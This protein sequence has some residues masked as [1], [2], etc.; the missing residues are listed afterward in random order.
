MLYQV[1]LTD[2]EIARLRDGPVS[3]KPTADALV[4]AYHE[5]GTW[6]AGMSEPVAWAGIFYG[7]HARL[8]RSLEEWEAWRSKHW[9]V[10]DSISKRQ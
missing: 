1:W 9:A 10:L 5:I 6:A 3:K 7:V 8:P 2:E 4:E